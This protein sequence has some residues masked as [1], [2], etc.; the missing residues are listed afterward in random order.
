METWNAAMLA[1]TPE[2]LT[3]DV[4]SQPQADHYHGDGTD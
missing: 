2:V 4:N 1:I 3:R